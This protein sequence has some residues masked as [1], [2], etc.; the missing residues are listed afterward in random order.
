MPANK[1]GQH[2]PA[3]DNGDL[4]DGRY[5][6]LGKLGDGVQGIVYRVWDEAH[7]RECALKLMG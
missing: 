7:Q 3:P 1:R 5:R 4:I 2:P 6:I